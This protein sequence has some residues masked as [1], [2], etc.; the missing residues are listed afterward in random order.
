MLY[1]NARTSSFDDAGCS[2]NTVIAMIYNYLRHRKI[3][4]IW[5]M[6]GLHYEVAEGRQTQILECGVHTG[7]CGPKVLNNSTLQ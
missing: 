4:E 5:R 6:S 1:Q 2:R 7:D 3:N